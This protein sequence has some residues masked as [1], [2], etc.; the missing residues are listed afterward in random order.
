MVDPENGPYFTLEQALEKVEPFTTIYLVEGV[1]TCTTP[2]NKPGII[3]QKRDIEKEVYIV[4][5]E[6]QVLRI[7]LEQ[8]DL[9]LAEWRQRRS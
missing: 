2:I 6:K 1:Y 3:I 9:D 8:E 7:E 5:N 4:G